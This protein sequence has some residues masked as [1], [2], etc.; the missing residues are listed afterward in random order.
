MDQKRHLVRSSMRLLFVTLLL[1]VPAIGNG[2]PF[3]SADT[4]SYLRVGAGFAGA[5]ERLVTPGAERAAPTAGRAVSAEELRLGATYLGARSAWYALPAWL[6]SR[7]MGIWGIAL[8][9][10][11]IAAALVLTA[12]RV[13]APA[14][15]PGPAAI[16]VLALASGSTLGIYA[17]V[18][19]PDL[20]VGLGVLAAGLLI[21]WS[22]RL[23]A[24][25]RFL[26][27]VLVIAAS[28]VHATHAPVILAAVSVLALVAS[29]SGSPIAWSRGPALLV[30]AACLLGVAAT[31]L[32]REAASRVVGEPLRNPPFLMAR[33]VADGP[34]RAFLEQACGT[35]A[36][37]LCAFLDRPLDDSQTILWESD[38]AR[39][40]FG[41]ADADT[42]IRLIEEQGEVLLG[43]LRT[44]PV[45]VVTSAVGNVL[46][47]LLVVRL[48]GELE[49]FIPERA[50]AALDE[51]SPGLA[52][53]WRESAVARGLW[54]FSI[55]DPWLAATTL[56]ALLV[57]AWWVVKGGGHG[58]AP[59]EV[60]RQRGLVVLVSAALVVNAVLCGAASGPFP[61]YQ[62][63][64]LWLLP[65]LAI[66]LLLAGAGRAASRPDRRP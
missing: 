66:L 15:A 35:R 33:V 58:G 7:A 50:L 65:A 53:A 55:L 62:M 54:P 64:I 22:D 44:D 38:P 16:A 52:D 42:R 13:V 34:G 36:L 3:V 10:A 14:A 26:L 57:V 56:A 24:I 21:L 20:F 40:V 46:R 9:Q 32:A 23:G 6:T 37:A 5:L 31:A 17:S 30:V 18:A 19:M 2:V 41:P 27:L 29:L 28:A 39:G 11:V 51:L 48:E 45:G 63:R 43:A 60:E 1:L 61:R 4:A 12:I 49:S 47:L 59:G 8:V 25:G